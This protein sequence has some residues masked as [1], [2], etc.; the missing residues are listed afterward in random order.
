MCIGYDVC[1]CVSPYVWRSDDK[2]Q[3]L[4]LSFYHVR[5]GDQT[6]VISLGS[7]HIYLFSCLVDLLLNDYIIWI[8]ATMT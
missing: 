7:K 8:W 4:I 2:L 3:E 6:W 1:V 5:P